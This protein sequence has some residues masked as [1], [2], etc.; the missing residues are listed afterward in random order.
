M[1]KTISA[2]RKIYAILLNIEN[3]K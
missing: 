2:P 3:L 1:A